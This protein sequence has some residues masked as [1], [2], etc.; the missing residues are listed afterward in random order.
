MK[1]K[2]QQ[3]E[4]GGILSVLLSAICAVIFLMIILF[5][6]SYILR[7]RYLVVE[8]VG[9]SMENTL[10]NGDI[11]YSDQKAEVQRGDIVIIDVSNVP[12]FMGMNTSVIIKRVIALE[13]DRIKCE[14]GVVYLA[15]EGGEY[16]QL[17]EPYIEGRNKDEFEEVLGEGEIFVMG[18]NR[19]GSMDSRR[20]GPLR[21]DNVIGTVP[22]WVLEYRPIIKSWENVND[23]L[24]GWV[25]NIFF[26]AG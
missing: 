23:L 8:V 16:E 5:A 1:K 9:T 22:E 7:R 15:V 17:D 2:D 10:Q 26:S 13:G 12:E 6:M 4:G 3:R 14:G 20:V 11:V 24:F 25:K 18:D 21:E 19:E